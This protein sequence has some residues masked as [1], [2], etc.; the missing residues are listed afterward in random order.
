MGHARPT[1]NSRRAL[2]VS[3]DCESGI[4][5]A[6]LF[7]RLTADAAFGAVDA[8]RDAGCT[9][10]TA[11]RARVYAQPKLSKCLPMHVPATV[12]TDSLPISD[13]ITGA[14]RLKTHS[15]SPSAIARRRQMRRKKLRERALLTAAAGILPHA[16]QP[17]GSRC[18]RVERAERIAFA[19]GIRAANAAMRERRGAK[20]ISKKQ[21]KARV[22]AAQRSARRR[23]ASSF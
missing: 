22:R 12:V 19:R 10:G 1:H 14:P 18:K 23:K 3:F 7:D 21:S 13:P 20:R 4:F 17:E 8:G 6:T 5:M 9:S 16:L 15:R 11:A 2:I